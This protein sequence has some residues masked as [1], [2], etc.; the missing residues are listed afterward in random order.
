MWGEL[1]FADRSL[2]PEKTS[3]SLG[4]VA[5]ELEGVISGNPISVQLLPILGETTGQPLKT[6]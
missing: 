3:R 5:A 1:I 4:R 6:A 2:S